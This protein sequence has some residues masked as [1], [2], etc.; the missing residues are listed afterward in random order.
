MSAVATP[1]PA[2]IS[3]K[4]VHA[5][6]IE[7]VTPLDEPDRYRLYLKGDSFCDMN[8][9]WF[10]RVPE[11]ASAVGGYLVV[12]EDGF[13]SWSPEGAFEKGYTPAEQFGLPYA[14][15]TKYTFGAGGRLKNRYTGQVIPD[16]EPV[17]VL[18]ARDV[19]AR[20]A[21]AHYVSLLSDSRHV[22][23]VGQRLAA[24]HE[25]AKDHAERMKVPD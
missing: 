23:E 4:T 15:E 14:Q 9:S 16:D 7:R 5:A 21:I 22:S 20:Q 25:F 12:Y 13:P 19:H 11:G 1:L 6:K 8:G 3:H 24:F 17:F 2:F 10:T 18:R